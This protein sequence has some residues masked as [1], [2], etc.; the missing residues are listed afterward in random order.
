MPSQV[1]KPQHDGSG[2]VRSRA[3]SDRSD[4]IGDGRVRASVSP[5]FQNRL[6]GLGEL[7]G[8]VVVVV[9]TPFN[10]QSQSPVICRFYQMVAACR[11][12]KQDVYPRA[13]DTTHEAFPCSESVWMMSFVANPHC[14]QPVGQ[15][16]QDLMATG[17]G[18]AS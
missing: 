11:L 10:I 13:K 2:G 16:V 8:E 18:L 17:I 3:S 9:Y 4:V 15:K 1:A 6:F 14:P 5:A 7:Q 12:D